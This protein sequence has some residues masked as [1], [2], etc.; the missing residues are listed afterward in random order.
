MK[1]LILSVIS[2]SLALITLVSTTYAWFS[3]NRN[4]YVD[5]IGFEVT[6]GE[7]VLLS[8]DG[9]HWYQNVTAD[10]IKKAAVAK[11]CG[12]LFDDNENLIDNDG[13]QIDDEK[14]ESLF[15]KKISLAPLSSTDGKI[16]TDL[17]NTTISET[18][19]KYLTFDL[20]FGAEVDSLKR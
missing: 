15:N 2:I 19:G 5:G 4:V 13:N 16:F 1:K 17:Y 20:Y 8:V 3:L 9:I 6:G 18:L 12:Y 11:Y 10:K 7:N 14:I